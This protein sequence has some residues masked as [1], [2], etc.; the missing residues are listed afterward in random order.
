MAAELG[1]YTEELQPCIAAEKA[2][3]VAD[4]ADIVVTGAD[5][6]GTVAARL[7]LQKAYLY[8]EARELE[9]CTAAAVDTVPAMQLVVLPI[10]ELQQELA[11]RSV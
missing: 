11:G 3:I 10:L 4:G 2:D 9:Q 1:H 5:I 8:N 6:A 7:D